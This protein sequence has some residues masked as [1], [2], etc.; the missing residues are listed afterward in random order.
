M[1]EC[2]V[3]VVE[4]GVRFS[5][6]PFFLLFGEDTPHFARHRA[7]VVGHTGGGAVSKQVYGRTVGGEEH[8]RKARVDVEVLLVAHCIF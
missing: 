4:I 8:K 3:R 5:V 2:G 7:V 1:A 6:V